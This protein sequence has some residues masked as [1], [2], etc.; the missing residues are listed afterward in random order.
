V[1]GD[2]SAAEVQGKVAR[3]LSLDVDGS[4]W[5]D[6]GLR[7][8]VVGRLQRMFPAF[9]PVNWSD[10][11]EAAAWCLISTRVSMRQGQG[12]K[13]RLSRES[14]QGVDVRA[15]L[16]RHPARRVR[17]AARAGHGDARGPVRGVASISDVGVRLPAAQRRRRRGDDAL[18]RVGLEAP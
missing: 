5:P 3:I 1:Y 9:R 12:V 7:D 10:A 4:G 17:P 16:A 2:A 11:Y 14:G 13:D 18:A 8:P 6:V 15:A